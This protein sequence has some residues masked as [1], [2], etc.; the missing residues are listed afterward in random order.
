SDVDPTRLAAAGIPGFDGA[1]VPADAVRLDALLESALTTVERDE[2]V[3]RLTAAGVPAVPARYTVE[4]LDDERLAA[5]E[6]FH[7]HALPDGRPYV[8][9]G[10]FAAFSR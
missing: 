8:T 3:R 2:A 7:E 5:A 9:A 4:L 1:S 6:T 10:R